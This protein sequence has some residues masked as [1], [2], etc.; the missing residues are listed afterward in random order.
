MV[1]NGLTHA[2]VPI[3]KGEKYHSIGSEDEEYVQIAR[4]I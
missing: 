4:I 3:F 2:L 1:S